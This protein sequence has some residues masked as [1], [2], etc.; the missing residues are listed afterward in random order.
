MS[1][2][3]VGFF[4]LENGRREVVNKLGSSGNNTS[5]IFISYDVVFQ[6]TQ[7][8]VAPANIRVYGGPTGVPL[9]ENTAAFVIAQAFVNFDG[10]ILMDAS[11]LVPVPG[12]TDDD[13]YGGIPDAHIPFIFGVGRVMQS[14]PPTPENSQKSFEASVSE[15]VR[16]ARNF[17]TLR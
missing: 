4:N 14:F 12:N 17:S 6:S 7:G 5:H 11:Y 1:F 9:G 3:V 16:D 15:Y 13:T 2:I 10:T 8:P